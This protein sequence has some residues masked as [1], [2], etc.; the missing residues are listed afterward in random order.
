MCLR[1]PTMLRRMALSQS[2]SGALLKIR[3]MHSLSHR[4]TLHSARS[5]PPKI[6]E[7]AW[8]ISVLWQSTS[9]A[10]PI[11]LQRT[12]LILHSGQWKH[13]KPDGAMCTE[14]TV[15]Y[16]IRKCLILSWN[17]TRTRSAVMRISSVRTGWAGGL[18]T[19][20]D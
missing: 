15:M 19:V 10:T 13:K 1:S 7:R 18:Q 17:N 9:P 20:L 11:L 12:I 4:L 14:P 6:S 16:L 8:E 5:L 2:W 3:Q